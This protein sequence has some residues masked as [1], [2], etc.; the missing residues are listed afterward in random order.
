MIS[1][2]RWAGVDCIVG[3]GPLGAHATQSRSPGGASTREGAARFCVDSLDFLVRQHGRGGIDPISTPTCVLAR[4]VAG[5]L[6]CCAAVPIAP[7]PQ[8]LE[9]LLPLGMPLVWR[10]AV[11]WPFK[12]RAFVGLR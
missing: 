10:G 6:V 11:C 8:V 1:E 3:S 4:R 12:R 5:A 9:E 7:R 2:A